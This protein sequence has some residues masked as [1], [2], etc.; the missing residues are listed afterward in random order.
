VW[1]TRPFGIGADLQR[2]FQQ[3][4]LRQPK[5]LWQRIKILIIGAFSDMRDAL[6]GRS[7]TEE[8]V[9]NLTHEIKSPLTAIRAAAELLGEPMPEPQRLRFTQNITLQVQRMQEMVDRLLELA[10]VEKMRTIEQPLRV[11]MLAVLHETIS[12]VKPIA[13]QRSIDMQLLATQHFYVLGDAFLLQRALSNLVSNALDFSPTNSQIIINVEL[14]AGKNHITVRDHGPGVPD[15]A[16][17]HIFEKFYSLRRPNSDRKSSGLGLA[18]VR[19]IA[20]LH[21]GQAYLEN[22]PVGGAIASLVLPGSY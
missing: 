5:R 16:L 17:S 10:S 13:D 6:A 14:I 22:H 21:G 4:G 9:Q 1:L 12:A 2:I 18:F 8:Y 19:E 7:Y 15:Y 11:D 20:Q 3:E